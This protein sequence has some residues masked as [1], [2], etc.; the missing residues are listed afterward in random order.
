MSDVSYNKPLQPWIDNAPNNDDIY[1]VNLNPLTPELDRSIYDNRGKYFDTFKFNQQ[2]D[3]YIRGQEKRRLQN[4][5]L[6]LQDLSDIENIEIKP[7]DMTFKEIL[8]GMQNTWIKIISFNFS[9]FNVN[10][11]FYLSISLISISLIYLVLY[12]LFQ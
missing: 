6:N 9:S 3:E 4:Q 7:Y 1:G 5:K 11:L 2:F 10:D 8:I 12:F